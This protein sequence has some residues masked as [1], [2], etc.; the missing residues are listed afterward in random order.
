M[1]SLRITISL[2]FV[3][4][5]LTGNADAYVSKKNAAY[6]KENV[7]NIG[8][9]VYGTSTAK[10]YK[11]NNKIKAYDGNFDLFSSSAK[12]IHDGV[13]PSPHTD[14]FYHGYYEGITR[15]AQSIVGNLGYLPIYMNR[16]PY[17]R[18]FYA[19][20]TIGEHIDIIKKKTKGVD[21][22]MFI[23]YSTADTFSSGNATHFGHIVSASV[24]IY[25]T[26]E[27][28]NML[29]YANKISATHLDI[30]RKKLR[31]EKAK[32]FL[33]LPTTKEFFN[34]RDVA[35]I[36]FKELREKI[37]GD[38]S[39]KGKSASKKEPK[40]KDAPI[41]PEHQDKFMEIQNELL[42]LVGNNP[43]NVE[44]LTVDEDPDATETNTHN[45]NV[46][47]K[48]STMIE[49]PSLLKR[50]GA[51]KGT[52]AFTKMKNNRYS[53]FKVG[54]PSGT[55]TLSP[56]PPD[57]AFMSMLQHVKNLNNASR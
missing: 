56:K 17:M 51:E 43:N 28:H 27:K 20:K 30:P 48:T 18:G 26:T 13:G 19:D 2:L 50:L 7:K 36:F 16:K 31:K 3:L 15:L 10:L 38:L 39:K 35:D 4:L 6:M 46:I 47:M 52:P 5:L 22:V 34:P 49:L 53:M 9:L 25:D 8:I 21:A 37:E 11:P 1:K 57:P 32:G 42:V 40:K 41:A 45:I 14:E 24:A 44:N 54:I 33:G 23:F 29:Y 55:Y 12:V